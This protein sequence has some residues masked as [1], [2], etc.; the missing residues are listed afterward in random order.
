MR[1]RC[2]GHEPRAQPLA[3]PLASVLHRASPPNRHHRILMAYVL[4][5]ASPPN[6]HH[7][8]LALL[9][10]FPWVAKAPCYSWCSLKATIT[11]VHSLYN[12]N[13]IG[14]LGLYA[15]LLVHQCSL[16]THSVS[17]TGS[18][19]SARGVSGTCAQAYKLVSRVK[20]PCSY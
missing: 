9:D 3:Q 14:K 19:V 7:R 11:F 17:G 16:F 10:V 1:A 20:G 18:S 15:M 4:H 8:I 6:R 5:R 12:A 2:R 13:R